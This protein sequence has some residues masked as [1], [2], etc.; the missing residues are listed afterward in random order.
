MIHRP[1]DEQ[2]IYRAF[3]LD[4]WKQ[5]AAQARQR[6]VE[7]RSGGLDHQFESE[8]WRQLKP[9]LHDYFFGKCA[10][11]E[12]DIAAGFWGDVEHYRPKKRV[13]DDPAHPGYYWLAYETSNLMP[14]CQKCNQGK[15]KKNWFPV[16]HAT[17]AMDETGVPLEQPLLLSPY[18]DFPGKHLKFDFDFDVGRP[19]GFVEGTTERGRKSVEIYGLNREGL[20]DGRLQAQRD[21]L[22]AWDA[23]CFS[24]RTMVQ[25]GLDEATCNTSLRLL[26]SSLKEGKRTYTAARIGVLEAWVEWGKKKQLESLSNLRW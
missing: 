24:Y 22:V 19:T 20:V 4:G 11:C 26:L 9:C 5:K 15:G 7:A 14:S 1:F 2:A 13:D 18:F 25:Q 17:R 10:Y 21:T 3:D 6:A 8:L 12:V 23:A 16:A